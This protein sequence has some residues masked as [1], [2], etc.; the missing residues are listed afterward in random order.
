MNPWK[1]AYKHK[2]FKKYT[3]EEIDEMLLCEL[4]EI[5]DNWHIRNYE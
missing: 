4:G 5:I 2:A 3:K 1:L